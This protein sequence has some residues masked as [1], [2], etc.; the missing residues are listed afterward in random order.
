MGDGVH[1]TNNRSGGVDPGQAEHEADT[2]ERRQKADPLV[3]I[4]EGWS[5]TKEER[6]FN[7]PIK[8][9]LTWAIL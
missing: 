8:I 7:G 4:L 9:H 5:P 6:Y 1:L 3:V 2:E